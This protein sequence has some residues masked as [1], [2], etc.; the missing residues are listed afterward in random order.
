MIFMP[1]SPRFHL[2]KR[3]PT[4]ARLALKWLRR[5]STKTH[6]EPE[7]SQ[8]Q[9]SIDAS[10]KAC[11]SSSKSTFKDLLTLPVLKPIGISVALM[12]FSQLSGMNGISLYT[13]EVFEKAG[14]NMDP[15]YALI[16]IWGAQA[17]SVLGVTFFLVENFGRKTLLVVSQSIMIVGLGAFGFSFY[18]QVDNKIPEDLAW[19][20]LVS[21]I[22]FIVGYNVG[23]GPLTWLITSEILP[24]HGRGK[25][26]ISYI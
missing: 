12:A 25:N 9:N 15:R 7:I 26:Y 8:I 22:T 17:L 3:Q 13:S 6:I 1:E 24:P 4:A 10:N 21:L 11:E 23:M 16:I 20:P 19:L 18:V 2:L 14:T 5:A